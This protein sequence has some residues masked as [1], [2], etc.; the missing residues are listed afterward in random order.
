V[1]IGAGVVFAESSVDESMVRRLII[2]PQKE[3]LSRLEVRLELKGDDFEGSSA[4]REGF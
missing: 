4:G 3:E 2:D 1:V